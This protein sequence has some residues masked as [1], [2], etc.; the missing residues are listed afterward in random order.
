MKEQIESMLTMYERG[1]INRRQF[2]Y[3]LAAVAAAPAALAQS[4]QPAQPVQGTFRGRIINH[5]TLSVADVNR[6]RAF[7][8]KLLGATDIFP[9]GNTDAPLRSADLRVGG[10]FIGIYPMGQPGR[11]DHFCV[12]IEHF[13][14]VKVMAQLK[15]HYP[16]T[17]PNTLPESG[18][19]AKDVYLTDPDGIRLQLSAVDLKL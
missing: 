2:L 7:Y 13:D 1:A 4:A 14:D 19:G 12:G 11:I 3:G 6:S 16:E 5:V 9:P 18:P 10:S 17:R 15:E 8:Q